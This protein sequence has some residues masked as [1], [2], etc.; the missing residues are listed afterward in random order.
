M[1]NSR[2]EG[3]TAMRA[4]GSGTRGSGTGRGA[5]PSRVSGRTAADPAR[6][7]NVAVVDTD[8]GFLLVLAKRLE[9]SG[10]RHQVLAR[11]VE[12]DEL[13]AMGVD[14]VI[15]DLQT[16]GSSSAQ[17]LE[18]LCAA[19][20][21]PAIIVCTG[22]STAT[23][24]VRA[25]RMGVDDWL[26]KPCHPEELIARVEV[27]LGSR[28]SLNPDALEPRLIGEL[29]VRPDQ[30]QAFAGGASLALTR[31]EYQ[32][33]V[34]LAS[35]PGATWKREVIYERLWGY[36]MVRNDRSVDVFV[37]KLRRKLSA[38]LPQWRYIHTETGVGYAFAP[39]LEEPALELSQLEPEP[40]PEPCE[41]PQP[42]ERPELLAA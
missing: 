2:G 16:L 38:A 22:S 42:P 41:L 39:E 9:R 17:W 36:E 13:T 31:R 10:W 23:E 37:H 14:A 20:R 21:Q 34:L 27:I 25:L 8:S 3:G 33:L 18:R 7:V 11:A 19:R 4:R 1:D 5:L 28:R 30:F 12:P 35:D 15:V 24:R 6:P 40:E 29:E 26:G 32:M